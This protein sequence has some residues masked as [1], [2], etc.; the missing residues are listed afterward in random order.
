MRAEG[1]NPLL[2]TEVRKGSRYELCES[3][4]GVHMDYVRCMDNL[5][6]SCVP[7]DSHLWAVSGQA[8]FGVTMV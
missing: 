5:C 7:M 2:Y 6:W 4:Y 3:H 8:T 1:G